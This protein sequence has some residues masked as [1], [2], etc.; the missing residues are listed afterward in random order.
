MPKQA[1]SKINHPP[2]EYKSKTNSVLVRFTRDRKGEVKEIKRIKNAGNL[3]NIMIEPSEV[4]EER[5]EA[6]GNV[7]E[8]GEG[9]KEA[10]K[11]VRGR[12]GRGGGQG[13]LSG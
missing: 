7:L 10:S 6:R 1:S 13:N 5:V 9:G 8:G 4:E 12:G 2:K 3:I 11:K